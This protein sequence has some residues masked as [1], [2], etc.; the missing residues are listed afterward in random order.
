MYMYM[1]K[2]PNDG[3]SLWGIHTRE[4]FYGVFTL[5]LSDSVATFMTKVAS[6]AL[7]IW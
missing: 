2:Q 5:R 7:G 6:V 1:Y 3:V 4:S